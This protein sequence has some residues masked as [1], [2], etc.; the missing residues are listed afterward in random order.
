[1][2]FSCEKSQ[3]ISAIGISGKVAS[4]KSSVAALEGLL[5]EAQEH[6]QITG[7]DLKTGI[8]TK[9]PAE[10]SVPGKLVLN[11][12]LFGEIIRKLPEDIVE[13]QVDENNMAT[14]TCGPSNFNIMGIGAE[15][16]PALP[17]VDRENSF[18][19]PQKTMKQMISQTIF[20]VSDNESR[21]I[22]TGSLFEIEENTLTIV[23]VDGYRLALRKE[24][25]ENQITSTEKS[26]VVPGN[27]LNEVEKISSESDEMIEISVDAKHILFTIGEIIVVS[28]RLEGEFLNYKQAI[29]QGNKINLTADKRLFMDAVDRVSLM[30]SEKLKTPVRCIFSDGNVELLTNTALGKARDMFPVTGDGENLEIGFNNRFLLEALKA[31]P[32]SKV[33]IS[34]GTSVSPCVISDAEGSDNFTYLVLP[35]RLQA[36][37]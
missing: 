33:N 29:P 17:V 30:I 6:L 5:L 4:S 32:A 10:V 1:M 9:V 35:V 12:R 20:A 27:A 14:I 3:L 28:R 34:L 2:K 8:Q 7:Y 11:A 21:P 26:F 18:S 24:K 36:G 16:Y 31:A 37:V 13:I 22:H 15:D 23:S 19:V 25:L